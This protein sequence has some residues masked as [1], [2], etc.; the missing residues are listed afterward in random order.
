[1]EGTYCAD[2]D[3]LSLIIDT[4]VGSDDLMAIAYLLQSENKKKSNFRI[5]AITVVGFFF[6]VIN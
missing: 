6:S 2:T 1:M 5:E 4:D 3:V